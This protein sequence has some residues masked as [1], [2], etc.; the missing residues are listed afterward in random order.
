MNM[1]DLWLNSDPCN[2]TGLRWFPLKMGCIMPSCILCGGFML[3]IGDL[4]MIG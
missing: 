1:G 3:E 4:E 2:K